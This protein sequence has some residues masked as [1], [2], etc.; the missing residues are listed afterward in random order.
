MQDIIWTVYLTSVR[1]SKGTIHKKSDTNLKISKHKREKSFLVQIST[2]SLRVEMKKARMSI[3][4]KPCSTC[5]SN[6]QEV[7][8]LRAL[9]D[10]ELLGN[11][12]KVIVNITV[13]QIAKRLLHNFQNNVQITAENKER[14]AIRFNSRGC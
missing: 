4:T 12:F 11:R 6:I 5:E 3:Q 9:Y 10:P 1:D 7:I 8:I 2:P 14:T 13:V